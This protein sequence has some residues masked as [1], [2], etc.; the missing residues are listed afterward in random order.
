MKEGSKSLSVP[1]PGAGLSVLLLE[2]M[3]GSAG[4]EAGFFEERKPQ[5][6][7]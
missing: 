1:V 4:E 5:E 2:L 3:A 6:C 7:A